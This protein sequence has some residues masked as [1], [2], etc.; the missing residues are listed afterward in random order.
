MRTYKDIYI[1]IVVGLL[2]AIMVFIIYKMVDSFSLAV[3]I[4]LMML[5][6]TALVIMT[7]YDSCK[8]VFRITVVATVAASIIIALY[9]VAEKLD[10]CKYF[11][12]F[13]T[14]KS[15]IL[16]TGNFGIAVYFFITVCQVV[17]LP[18]PAAVTILIGVA[19]Y[20]SAIA[21]LV[22]LIG[23]FI[24][25]AICFLLGKTFGR[26]LVNWMIGK[27]TADK[28]ANLLN[29]KGKWA[30]TLMLIFPFFPDDTLCIIAGTTSM[31]ARFF[32]LN[33]LFA[34]PLTIAF[35]SFF[36]SGEII[37]YKGWG[38]PVWIAIFVLCV[39]VLIFAPK[40]KEKLFDSK[41]S[42]LNK[43]LCAEAAKDQNEK[44]ISKKNERNDNFECNKKSNQ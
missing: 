7:L 41:S 36:G 39:L 3:K 11:K 15:V 21:F 29:E 5:F 26:R 32:F 33:I 35:I 43:N 13:N 12:D 6:L 34:R 17:F 37:P 18:I 1:K 38:I 25:S 20:G 42:I 22:S 4:G 9:V 40:I 14:I 2:S 8:P 16:S 31:S 24:G 44:E 23:T 28:Y 10:L 27:E 19:I 30:F